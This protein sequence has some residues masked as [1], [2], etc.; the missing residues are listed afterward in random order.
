MASGMMTGLL[1]NLIGLT[2]TP[3]Q[4]DASNYLIDKE[5]KPDY[6]PL[7]VGGVTLFALILVTVVLLVTLK[8]K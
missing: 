8:K 5:D 2:K 6:T 7:V 3:E 4:I 1:G